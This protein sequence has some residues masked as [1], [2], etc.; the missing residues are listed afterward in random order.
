MN[1]QITKM[2][3]S[4]RQILDTPKTGHIGTNSSIVCLP[5]AFYNE[6]WDG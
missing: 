4:Q 5:M 6:G 1:T 3:L 2:K